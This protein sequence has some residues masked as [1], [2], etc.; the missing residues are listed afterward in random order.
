MTKHNVNTINSIDEFKKLDKSGVSI[1]NFYASFHEPCLH[2]NT[3]FEETSRNFPKLSYFLVDAEQVEEL[4]MDFEIET[5]PTFVFLKDGKEIERIE[6]SNAPQLSFL[7]SKYQNSSFTTAPVV[8]DLKDK[9]K[10]LTTSHPVMLFMKGVPSQ[11]R[12]GFSRQTVE[13]LNGLNI[14]Y[15]SFDILAD[16]SVRQGLKEY[17][18]WPT[19]PQI[20]VN[21]EFIGGLD[22]L[23]EMIA[24]GEFQKL[25]PEEE[26][27]NTR[28]KKLI[29]RHKI[30]LFMKGD[31]STP[32]CGFSRVLVGIL[33]D[34]G[35][36]FDTF[37]I[38]QDEE[39][40]QG[41]KEY[42]DWPTFPQLYINGELIGGLDIVKELINNGEFKDLI[43]K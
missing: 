18:D 3:V 14:E 32:K 19:F 8:L 39:V 20:Y 16:E 27:L 25:L 23:K 7:A 24:S 30:M 34:Q 21:G 9:L 28:L 17:S 1:I 29:N 33:Q 35:C 12:C 11:P 38:L 6:G 43:P 31:P 15:G 42:S 26:D 2:M 41:L 10:T 36:E 4:A 40:R 22:I 13:L 37:D 5:V